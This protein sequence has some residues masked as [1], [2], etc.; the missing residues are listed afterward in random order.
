M[1][2]KQAVLR[3]YCMWSWLA[4]TG[5]KTKVSYPL[6][7][8]LKFHRQ[9]NQCCLCQIYYD[10]NEGCGG[11]ILDIG[12]R[13]CWTFYSLYHAWLL[14]DN[15]IENRKLTAGNIAAICWK[16]YKELGG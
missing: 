2:E 6:F 13:P 4:V 14:C 8:E 9:L 7:F 12:G 11:C 16:R 15:S 1:T 5:A 3:T 10:P